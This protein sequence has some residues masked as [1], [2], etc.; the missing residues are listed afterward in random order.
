MKIKS[1]LDYI[2]KNYS[3][4]KKANKIQ[5]IVAKAGFDYSDAIKAIDKVIEES[6]ELKK[7]IVNK[8]KNRTKEELGDLIFASLDVSRKLNLNPEIILSEANKKFT[9][10]WKKI[11]K[12]ALEEN[13]KL[14]DLNLK[15][16]NFYWNKAKK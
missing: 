3:A 12:Y 2:P 8:K 13:K 14:K 6:N 11:E 5:K 15:D 16:F 1:L 10:R 7:E 9:G 4:L